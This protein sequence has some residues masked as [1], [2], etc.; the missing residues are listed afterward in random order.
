[1]NAPFQHMPWSENVIVADADYIDRVAFDLTV[2]FE[3]MLG[4]RIPK[5]DLAQWLVC[6]GLDGGMR[7]GQQSST[8]V[9]L[10]HAKQRSQLDNFMPSGIDNELNGRAFNDP[11]LGE[12]TIATVATEESMVNND[13]LFLD[14]VGTI[15]AQNEVRR[16]MIVPNAEE[17]SLYDDLRETIRRTSSNRE[18]LPTVTLFTMEPRQGGRFQQEL[19]GYSLMAALGIRGDELQP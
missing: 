7:P 10:L 9:V 2:N 1:M 15:L 18:E 11:M 4:R 17:G 13:D 5:A 19:L 14:I 16:V 6:V 3:R 8:Q 12:F